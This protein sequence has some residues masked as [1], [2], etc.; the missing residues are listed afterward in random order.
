MDRRACIYADYSESP[1]GTKAD[2]L[3]IQADMH[4]VGVHTQSPTECVF[5]Y[6][7]QVSLEKKKSVT[8]MWLIKA[9]RDLHDASEAPPMPFQT[10]K[11]GHNPDA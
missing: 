4:V 3:Q 6:N 2:P 9:E 7:M 1:G 8:C 10:R 11:M 5:A